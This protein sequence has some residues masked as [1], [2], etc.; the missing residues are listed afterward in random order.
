MRTSAEAQDQVERAFF[1]Y[2]IIGQRTA[3]IELFAGENEALLVGGDAF[4]VLDLG[5]DHVDGVRGFDFE[6]DRFAGQRFAEDLHAEIGLKYARDRQGRRGPRGRRCAW[7]R[8]G[9]F[10]RV[11]VYALA[12][13]H[14][15]PYGPIWHVE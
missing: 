12:K 2:V 14:L 15:R 9:L 1:L 8:R 11:I 13:C 7:R 3:L 4:L 10:L 5:L 6:C